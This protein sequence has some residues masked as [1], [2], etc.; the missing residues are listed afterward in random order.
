M[1]TFGRI[2][3]I[4]VCL[5]A[6]SGCTTSPTQS[7]TSA[8]PNVHSVDVHNLSYLFHE[9]FNGNEHIALQQL[10]PDQFKVTFP[11]LSSFDFAG[12][13]I[14][15]EQKVALQEIIKVLHDIEFQQ[16]QVVGHTDNRGNYDYNLA[17]S[18]DRAKVVSDYLISQG[19][20]SNKISTIGKGPDEPIADNRQPSGQAANRRVELLI[21]L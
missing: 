4:A 19:M 15:A 21:Q 6:V 12:R 2:T 5:L 10:Q 13:A 9:H 8:E 18:S 14:T 1:S 16:L 20:L 7:L 11:G 3:C 17:L